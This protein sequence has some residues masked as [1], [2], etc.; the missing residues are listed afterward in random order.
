[1]S[2]FEAD[3]NGVSVSTAAEN[4]TLADF[5]PPQKP[6]INNGVGF[7]LMIAP[8]YTAEVSPASSC[9]FLT[10]FPELRTDL[11]WRTVLER[12]SDTK[13][14]AQLRLTDIKDAAGIPQ[15]CTDDLVHVRKQTH[16]ECVWRELLLHPTQS[17]R[18]VLICVV[19]IHFF[20]QAI[21]LDSIVLYSP[22]IFEKAGI[23]SSNHKLLPTVAVGFVKTIFILVATFILDKIGRRPLL[24]SS[25][26]G[27]VISLAA[28]G[29]SLTV[30]DLSDQIKVTW[31]VG[32][33]IAMVLYV[34]VF[35]I[36][37]MGPVT[38]VYSTEILPLR[39]RAQGASM[40]VTVNGGTSGL[41][42]MTFIH[43][44]KRLPS[45]EPSSCTT[46]RK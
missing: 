12:T 6:K 9:G 28:L 39:L 2:G 7:A 8:V 42:S 34:A 25:A 35:S 11:V 31:A 30:I 18:H 22:R 23:T 26:A 4:K 24:L 27:I 43:C 45:V 32:L 13:E 15:D 46:G 1:M 40:G 5:E 14:E 29:L 21:G 33:C 44:T 38:W 20:Q 17:V 41:I 37:R 19:G 3:N 16:G 10:S 36:G